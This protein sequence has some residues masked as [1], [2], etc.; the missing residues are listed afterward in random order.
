[1]GG[2]QKEKKR[3]DKLLVLD[4][5]ETIIYCTKEPLHRPVDFLAGG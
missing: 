5:D 1:M 4:L 2:S 3:F